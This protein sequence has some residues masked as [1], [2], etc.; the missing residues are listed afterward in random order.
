[1]LLPARHIGVMG[2]PGCIPE[3]AQAPGQSGGTGGTWALS[4]FPGQTPFLLIFGQADR[5]SQP[6]H[7]PDILLPRLHQ[8]PDLVPRVP[9]HTHSHE[10]PDPALEWNLRTSSSCLASAE[11]PPHW[12]IIKPRQTLSCMLVVLSF[13]LF[14]WNCMGRLAIRIASGSSHSKPRGDFA[15][16]KTLYQNQFSLI[17]IFFP[18]LG[19]KTQ[20]SSPQ[21]YPAAMRLAANLSRTGL[22]PTAIAV[23]PCVGSGCAA[24]LCSAQ[25]LSEPTASQR[26]HAGSSIL[27]DTAASSE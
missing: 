16:N 1:M 11:I 25:P 9:W 27:G 18:Y 26:C 12:Q 10:H 8:R 17:L 2:C 24:W 20:L 4:C 6:T 7:P 19:R 13:T 22:P 23:S 3:R 5:V 15:H 14:I 21:N